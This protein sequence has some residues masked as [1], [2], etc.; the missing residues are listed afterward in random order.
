MCQDEILVVKWRDP[1]VIVYLK[2][3]TQLG[4]FWSLIPKQP[5]VPLF[6]I[7]HVYILDHEEGPLWISNSTANPFLYFR[8][9]LAASRKKLLERFL[10]RRNLRWHSIHCLGLGKKRAS[11]KVRTSRKNKQIT[12]YIWLIFMVFMQ[13]NIPVPWIL[14][15]WIPT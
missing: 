14:W 15:D 7:A 5:F 4:S 13:V 3:P 11:K 10:A 1:Y 8:L 9:Q 12:S 6:F 2:I